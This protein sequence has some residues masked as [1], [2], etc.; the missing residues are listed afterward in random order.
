MADQQSI[1]QWAVERVDNRLEI[2][3]GSDFAPLPADFEQGQSRLAARAIDDMMELVAQRGV[4]LKGE[5]E[6]DQSPP[7][8][9]IPVAVRDL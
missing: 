9:R 2:G 6:A 5:N 3:V 4:S 8:P 7:V 1:Y